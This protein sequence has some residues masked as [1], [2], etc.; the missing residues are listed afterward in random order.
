MDNFIDN[1]DVTNYNNGVKSG[2]FG[3]YVIF[4][5][6]MDGFIDNQDASFVLE[7]V[8]RS[9]VSPATYFRRIIRL[10]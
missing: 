9:L 3:K 2:N 4:D 7:N 5:I 6:N 10:D 1:L 8:K